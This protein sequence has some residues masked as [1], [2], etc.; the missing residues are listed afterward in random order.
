MVPG[1]AGAAPWGS[2]PPPPSAEPRCPS[3]RTGCNTSTRAAGFSSLERPSPASSPAAASERG[4]SAWRVM[5]RGVALSFPGT[6]GKV[7]FKQKVL[8]VRGMLGSPAPSLGV[9]PSGRC[10]VRGGH[11]LFALAPQSATVWF[12]TSSVKLDRKFQRRRGS[13]NRKQSRAVE[14]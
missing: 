1:Q 8:A 2:A 7:S 9:K 11:Q 13:S 4:V 5:N 6:F 14:R 10:S 3:E 12:S